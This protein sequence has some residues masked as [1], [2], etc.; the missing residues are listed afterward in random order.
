[1]RI[2]NGSILETKRKTV[3]EVHAIVMR[4]VKVYYDRIDHWNGV[5][6]SIGLFIMRIYFAHVFGVFERLTARS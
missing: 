2:M 5:F 3:P 4:I 1:M 6:H